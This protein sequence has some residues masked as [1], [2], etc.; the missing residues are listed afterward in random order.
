MNVYEVN[1]G[2]GHEFVVLGT[3]V[4]NP[5]RLRGQNGGQIVGQDQET[6]ED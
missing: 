6:L 1:Y 3:I 4:Y 5:T 2:L